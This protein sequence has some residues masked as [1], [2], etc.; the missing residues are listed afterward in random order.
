MDN[1]KSELPA[2]TPE[3]WVRYGLQNEFPDHSIGDPIEGTYGQ[4]WILSLGDRADLAVKTV[5][6]PERKETTKD[7]LEIF[8]RELTIS[9]MLPRHFNVVPIFGFVT[10]PHLFYP[11]EDGAAVFVSALKMGAMHGCLDDWVSD[12]HAATLENRLIAAAQA[13]TGLQH[14][15]MSG[16]EGHGDIKPSNL[17]YADMRDK[18]PAI[19][20]RDSNDSLFPSNRYPYKVVVADL[21]WADAWVDLGH[22]KGFKKKVLPSYCA[23]EREMEEA[24]VVPQKS[25]IFSMGILLASLLLNRH[26]ARDFKKY[27]RSTGKRRRCIEN[28]DWDLS[29]IESVRI[30]K[31]VS[32]CLSLSPKD[33]PSVD[34]FIDE[35]CS[36]L[37]DCH[38]V[39]S[40]KECLAI[41][42]D[43]YA[44]SR[45]EHVA[46]ASRF[47]NRTS[48]KESTRSLKM[49]QVSLAKI[50]VTDFDSLKDW[51]AL[52]SATLGIIADESDSFS[53]GLRASARGYLNSILAHM[54][55]DDLETSVSSDKNMAFYQKFEIF[56]R[57][58]DSI[59][60]RLQSSYEEQLANENAGPLLLAASAFSYAG[61][62]KDSD[63]KMT[64]YYLD[65]SLEHDPGQAVLYYFD[66]FWD[67][68][69]E[70]MSMLRPNRD[71]EPYTT[72]VRLSKLKKAI[73]LAPKWKEP[74][75]LLDSLDSSYHDN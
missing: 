1:Q 25:D 9:L 3:G 54:N 52:A 19:R 22:I 21:G 12:P 68:E 17:L 61:D 58:V 67:V 31:L 38:G 4:V 44:S 20:E 49:L 46:W 32:E 14:L 66:V 53:V 37:E 16:F 6:M 50:N 75:Q 18:H 24:T 10:H 28:S 48:D 59:L 57:Q 41:Q 45:S 5:M 30:S 33:R 29:G 42:N 34:Y 47:T 26:P 15:Y 65:K 55:K 40:L 36:E 2:K 7:E 71:V 23:P 60:D 13:A 51:S 70:E 56:S 63:M 69:A 74:R 62:F 73:S 27:E 11:N 64:R 35:I 72:E 43:V 8:E 39:E